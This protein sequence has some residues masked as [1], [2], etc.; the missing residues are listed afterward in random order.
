MSN[1][2][3]YEKEQ[4]EIDKTEENSRSLNFADLDPEGELKKQLTA[5]RKKDR[6]RML[7]TALAAGL[8]LTIGVGYY[9]AD[10]RANS[11]NAG[12]TY[13]SQTGYV[14]SDAIAGGSG[15]GGCCGGGSG[16]AGGGGGCGGGGSA[17]GDASLPDLEKQAL[18]EYTKETGA[19]DVTAKASDFGCHIQ[20]DISDKTGKIV[21]SYGYQGG[22]LYVIK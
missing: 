11:A 13:G 20:M 10:A 21:R 18:A 17:L 12:I 16:S 7:I 9:V 3:D 19:K 1:Y 14:A 22:S 6:A 5:V 8:M 15:A 4:L 2:S